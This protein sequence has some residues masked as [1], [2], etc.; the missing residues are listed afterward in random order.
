MKGGP[1]V[2]KIRTFAREHAVIFSILWI[3]AVIGVFKASGHFFSGEGVA[4]VVLRLALSG[5][6]LLGLYEVFGWTPRAMGLRGRGLIKGILLDWPSWIMVFIYGLIVWLV[7]SGNVAAMTAD[8]SQGSF[9]MRC[10]DMLK[11][12]T[13][14]TIA[15]E[16]A[17]AL[18]VGLFEESLCRGSVVNIL[19]LAWSGTRAG[20][21]KTALLSGLFF[22]LIHSMN[23]IGQPLTLAL[24]TYTL[25][26]MAQTA[27][28]G[29]LWA[30]IYQRTGNLLICVLAHG[31]MDAALFFMSGIGGTQSGVITD[32]TGAILI[33]VFEVALALF[34]LRKTEVDDGLKDNKEIQKTVGRDAGQLGQS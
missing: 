3:A 1:I 11:A 28:S 33:G 21:I 2:E 10:V 19:R 29:V 22:G 34:Y 27:G 5:L 31:F 25:V 14:G 6:I 16:T 18:S 4:G 12:L 24:L 26:Q 8:A 32:P 30:A 7:L 20:A 13:P 17:L 9:V 23:L 15:Y